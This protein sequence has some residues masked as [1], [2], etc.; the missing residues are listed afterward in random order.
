MFL[1]G[2]FQVEPDFGVKTKEI[3]LSTN[4]NDKNPFFSAVKAKVNREMHS[5]AGIQA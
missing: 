3:F 5:F 1:E 4:G 2:W